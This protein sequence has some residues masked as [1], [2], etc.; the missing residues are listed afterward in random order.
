MI[1]ILFICHG[2]IPPLSFGKSVA[3]GG[4]KGNCRILHGFYKACLFHFTCGRYTMNC[5]EDQIP[6]IK[7]K[8][9]EE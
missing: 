6:N 3:H 8:K 5:T 7:N 9:E 2:K 4:A 1:K